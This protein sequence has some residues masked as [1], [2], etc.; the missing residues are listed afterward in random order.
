MANENSGAVFLEYAQLTVYRDALRLVAQAHELSTQLPEALG[1]LASEIDHAA[2]AAVV[3]IADS[4]TSEPP[5]APIDLA[6]APNPE[7]F[8]AEI[9]IHFA[10]RNARSDALRC[11]VLCD[12]AHTVGALGRDQQTELR[13]LAWDVIDQIDAHAHNVRPRGAQLF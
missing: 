11:T 5:P 10:W 2:V 4:A 12:V 6:A 1:W 9:G 8:G 13:T 7:D 3:H